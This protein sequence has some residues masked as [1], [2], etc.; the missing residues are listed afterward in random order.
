MRKSNLEK[1][2]E[3]KAKKSPTTELNSI[4]DLAKL[5]VDGDRPPDQRRLNPTQKAFIYAPDRLTAYKGP[6][7]CA[8]TSTGC[9]KI[10]LR[11]L[12]EPGTKYLIAR[13]D[14]NDLMDTTALRMQEMLSRLPPGT[15]LGRDKT[16]PMKWYIRP[17]GGAHVTSDDPSQITFMGLKEALGSYEFNGAFVD[18]ADEVEEARVHE[19][20]TRL[21]HKGGNYNVS[22]AFNPPDVNHWLYTACTGL[23]G[24]N[25]HV[26][27]P[28]LKLFEPQPDENVANLP[29]D[30]YK[31]LTESLPEDMRQRLVDGLWGSSF[32]GAPVIRQFR[33]SLHV[34]KE[35]LVFTSEGTLF[36]FW[37]FGYGHPAC[38]WVQVSWNGRFRILRELLGKQQEAASFARRVKA[39][40]TEWFPTALRVMDYGDPAVKQ[41]KDT[42]QTLAVIHNEGITIHY[43]N[44]SFDGSLQLLRRQ[45]ERLIEGE[46][47]I[48]IDK[49]CTFLISGLSGGYHL[50]DDGTTPVKDG[51]YDH[52]IDALRYG[53]DNVIGAEVQHNANI[54]TSVAYD[55]KFDR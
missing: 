18:E 25:R 4:D 31:Y 30:Y 2:V 33:R 51:F 3:A 32:P 29:P 46:P 48:L 35:P 50:K 43:K 36:R 45:F 40:T 12:L 53:V 23:D 38:L 22:L 26:K 52:L 39:L 13:H 16:P 17:I 54:P 44:H 1:Y 8:K 24:Q 28:F 34:A 47:A 49:R 19:I 9:A 5:L 10:F 41:K 55:P 14:Y 27:P 11:A 6:A 20:N 42:G 15:L 7:G 21:R 37:D